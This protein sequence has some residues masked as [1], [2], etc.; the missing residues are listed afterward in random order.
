LHLGAALGVLCR[1]QDGEFVAAEASSLVLTGPDGLQPATNSRMPVAG[2]MAE[3]VVDPLEAVE[4]DEE[5]GE[6]LAGRV[7]LGDLAVEHGFEALAIEEAGQ[8]VGDGLA[9]VAVLGLP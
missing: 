1:Q 8:V 4:I 5:A 2:G 3:I 7:G 9:V 6:F